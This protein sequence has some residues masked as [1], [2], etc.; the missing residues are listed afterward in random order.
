MKIVKATISVVVLAA[1]LGFASNA[2]GRI[3]PYSS[4]YQGH[5]TFAVQS[6][7]GVTSGDVEFAVY[8]TLGGNEFLDDTGFESPG[9]GQYIYA[10]Q[11]FNDSAS[12]DPLEY[13]GILGIG[14]GAITESDGIG[15][16]NDLSG[17][18]DSSYFDFDSEGPDEDISKAYWEF[19]D[20]DY[21]GILS[22]SAHS[23]FLVLT[24]DHP[25]TRGYFQVTPDGTGAIPNPE[26]CSLAL[27]GLGS[28]VLLK[29][30]GKKVLN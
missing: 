29:R 9:E 18:I 12:D 10:Y 23:F 5:S 11:V 30:P 13:F 21:N 15:T 17:G 7:S 3:L 16:E 4:Y 20:Q 26:P 24:S 1:A 22:A 19:Y 14:Q 25:W 6:E 2:Y 8:D 28:L 27:L